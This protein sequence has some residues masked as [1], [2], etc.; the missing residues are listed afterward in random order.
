MRPDRRSDARLPGSQ[1]TGYNK[2]MESSPHTHLTRLDRVWLRDPVYFVTTCTLHRRCALA[3]DTAHAICVEV[4]ENARSLY[5]WHVGRYV[6]MPDHVHFFCAPEQNAKPLATF[7]GKWK[8]WTAKYLHR[9]MGVAVPLWQ[10]EF[11]DHLLRSSESYSQKWE[12]VRQNPVRPGLV[13]RH[14]DWPHQ[15]CLTDLRVD[16]VE[17]L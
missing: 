10:E 12:Y 15:G 5:G 4:W 17:T 3:N 14:E 11:F 6:I 1:T 13:P 8:E 9:R 2:A 7:V 16:E